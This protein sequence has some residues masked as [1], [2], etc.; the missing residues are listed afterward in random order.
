MPDMDRDVPLTESEFDVLG[1]L[2][3]GDVRRPQAMTTSMLDG[4]LAALACRRKR[5]GYFFN[6]HYVWDAHS[7]DEPPDYWSDEHPLGITGL[8]RWSPR[9]TP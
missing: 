5:E 8:A 1:E 2:L 3:N 9:A 6:M 4:F 7:G